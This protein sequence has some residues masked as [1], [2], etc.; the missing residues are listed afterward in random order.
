MGG[1]RVV[2]RR[3]LESSARRVAARPVENVSYNGD[4]LPAISAEVRA[5]FDIDPDARPFES[6]QNS[7]V[8]VNG[9]GNVVSFMKRGA[10]SA[11]RK[12]LK[13]GYS[14]LPKVFDVQAVDLGGAGA[15]TAVEMERLEP[16]SKGDADDLTSLYD[17]L[18]EGI[19]GEGTSPEEASLSE[20]ARYLDPESDTPIERDLS[21]LFSRMLKEGV[22]HSDLV[23]NS[24]N[25]ARDGEGRLK[26][27]D[28]EDVR[29][30]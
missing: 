22:D 18:H 21:D 19:S 24:G 10:P 16:L 12:A 30:S 26:L 11:L 3:S 23:Y 25:L 6:G 1:P 8:F 14:C 5:R 17:A 9:R 13:G 29:V 27:L 2:T 4:L 15:A 20:T 7:V 28:F